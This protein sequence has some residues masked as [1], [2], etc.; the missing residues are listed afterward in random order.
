M[1]TQSAFSGEINATQSL[2]DSAILLITY[3]AIVLLPEPV[4][5]RETSTASAFT[6]ESQPDVTFAVP[7]VPSEPAANEAVC[8]AVNVLNEDALAVEPHAVPEPK[9]AVAGCATH[10]MYFDLF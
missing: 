3:V 8:A 7:T 10:Q 6:N 4:T 5:N 2:R 1:S 9:F